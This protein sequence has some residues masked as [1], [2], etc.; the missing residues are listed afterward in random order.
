VKSGS[1]HKG[2]YVCNFPAQA[3]PVQNMQQNGTN[4]GDLGLFR[5][6]PFWC[7]SSIYMYIV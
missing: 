6:C 1:Q 2:D 7:L 3:A 4:F 5:H